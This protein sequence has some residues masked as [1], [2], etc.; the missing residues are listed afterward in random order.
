[1]D[2]EKK[3]VEAGGTITQAPVASRTFCVISGKED[4][5]R[6]NNIKK[7]GNLDVLKVSW[8]LDT[9]EA[10]Y[11]LPIQQKH[12][13][14]ATERTLKSI[15]AAADIFGDSFTQEINNEE[16]KRLLTKPKWPG[17]ETL[18]VE[19]ATLIQEVKDRYFSDLK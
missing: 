4:G 15:P 2:L 11:P 5:L 8:L 13:I 14:F 1:M 12:I 19:A 6:L 7:Q 10:R 16:L 17:A 9:L 18:S 3:I